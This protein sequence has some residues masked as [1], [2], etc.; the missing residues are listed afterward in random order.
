MFPHL[1]AVQNQAKRRTWVRELLSCAGDVIWRRSQ[2]IIDPYGS[3]SDSHIQSTQSNKQESAVNQ[4]VSTPLS[5]VKWQTRTQTDQKRKT[6]A[7][8]SVRRIA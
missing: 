3:G 8:V 4:G 5:G 6:W 7:N 1:H 2:C